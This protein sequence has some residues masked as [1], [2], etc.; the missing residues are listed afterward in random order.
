MADSSTQLAPIRQIEAVGFR[1]WPASSVHYDGSWAIRLTASHPSKR[2]N[3]VN[4]LDPGDTDNLEERVAQ[5]IK[6]FRACGRQPVF[7]LSPLAPKA[8]DAY[9]DTL[10]WTRFDE[11]LVMLADLATVDLSDAIDQIPLQDIGWYVDAA[12]QVQQEN[13]ALKPGLLEVISAIRPA[14]GLFVIEE[15]DEPVSTAICVHDGALAGLFNIGTLADRRRKGYGR[16]IVKSAIKWAVQHGAKRGWLQVEADNAGA[17][18]LYEKI[19]F[20]EAYRYAYRRAPEE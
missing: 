16:M 8:L 9:L 14:K 7:R 10:G 19:G 2:L 17:I 20:T 15:G 13:P 6:R 4:P 18:A 3:S 11:S 5:A 1:A 12:V